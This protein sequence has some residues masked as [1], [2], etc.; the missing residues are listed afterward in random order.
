MKL[1]INF[2]RSTRSLLKRDEAMPKDR[3][4]ISRV[5]RSKDVAKASYDRMSRW[6]DAIAGSSEWKFVQAGIELLNADKGEKV[7]DIGYGTGKSVLALAHTVGKTGS[8][9]GIDLS[10]GM[11][12]MA[13]N[14]LIKAGISENVDLRCGDAVNLPFKDSSFDAVFSSFTLEL[15]D[16]PEIPQVLQECQRVLRRPGRIVIVSMSKKPKES[17]AVKLYEWAHA[18]L[19]TF[20]DCRPIYVMESI[21]TA[22]FDVIESVEM[23]MWGLPVDAVLAKKD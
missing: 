12:E 6:Y 15:F 7:L 3:T 20:F 19:P 1:H 22:G 10:K 14:R 9:S 16:T 17:I 21:A 23:R 4:P 8:V 11:Y 2:G 13:L 5:T 18:K